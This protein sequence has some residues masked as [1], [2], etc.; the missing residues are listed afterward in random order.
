MRAAERLRKA[1]RMPV[2]DK[3]ATGR[4]ITEQMERSGKNVYEMAKAIG[5]Q[6]KFVQGYMDGV[7]VPSL[8][9]LIRMSDALGVYMDE[10]IVATEE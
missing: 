8:L 5:S 2:I 9:S 6:A 10:L 3:K 1:N 7:S 4:K